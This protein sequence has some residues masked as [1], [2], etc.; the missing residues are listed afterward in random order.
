M[1]QRWAFVAFVIA[2]LPAPA[3]SAEAGPSATPSPS[4]S[5]QASDPCDG[6]DRLLATANRPTIGF[7]ACAAKKGTA[8]FELG[9][10]NQVNG[11][12]A[13]GSVVSQ[14]PQTFIRYGAATRFELDVVGP[15]YVATRSYPDSPVVTHGVTD[16]GVGFKYELPPSSRWTLAFD[17]IYTGPNGSPF[18]TAGSASLTGNLDASF[19]LSPSVSLGT[20]IAFSSTGAYANAIPSRYGVT[21]PSFVITSE[22]PNFYQ[23]Y[24]EY[25]YV[26]KVGPNDGGR[27]FTDFGVQKLLGTRTEIDVEYGHAFTGDRA[28]QFDYIGSGLVLQLW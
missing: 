3:R 2:A 16:S 19:S 20:T 6:P 18:L 23:F 14:V 25:V 5:P 22:I 12:P 4:P 9:Y 21:T 13:N 26:S 8:L 11:T 15:N 24:A 17:G 1:D 27:A 7:S 28:L 10:Q